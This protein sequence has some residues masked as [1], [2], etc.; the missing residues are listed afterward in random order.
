MTDRDYAPEPRRY[1]KGE[2]RWVR[3]SQYDHDNN[4]VFGVVPGWEGV[5]HYFVLEQF[6]GST[7]NVVEEHK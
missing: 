3:A 1:F 2:M 6:N 4:V 5:K 7:W